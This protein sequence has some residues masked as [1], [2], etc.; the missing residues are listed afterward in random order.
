M[1]IKVAFSE[2]RPWSGAKDTMEYL[3]EKGVSMDQ[4]EAV[5]EDFFTL[6][7]TDTEVNDLLWFDPEAVCHAL[8]ILWM[9]EEEDED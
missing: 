6:P 4:L 8:G 5:L 7:P 3:R 1:Y 9:D 2:Y